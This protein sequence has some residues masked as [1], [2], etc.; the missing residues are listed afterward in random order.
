M[1]GA[2]HKVKNPL[3]SAA[4]EGFP[5]ENFTE[6]A[7]LMPVTSTTPAVLRDDTELNNFVG[8]EAINSQNSTG[9]GTVANVDSEFTPISLH[10]EEIKSPTNQPAKQGYLTSILSSLPNLSLSSIT[11]DTSGSQVNQGSEN[12]TGIQST[13][14]YVPSHDRH[15]SLRDISP[16][17]VS[18]FHD[19]RRTNFAGSGEINPG[20]TGGLSAPPQPPLPPAIPASTNGPI[21]Y[22]L[23]NQRRLKYA[24]PPDLISNTPK[25]YSAPVIQPL[26]PPQSTTS[27]IFTPNEPV[28]TTPNYQSFETSI[29]TNSPSI[30]HSTPE[31]LS[32]ANSLQE[33]FRSSPITAAVPY[34]SSTTSR[35]VT[36]PNQNLSYDSIPVVEK[37]NNSLSFP[38]SIPSQVLE[39]TTP[40]NTPAT[41]SFFAFDAYTG[42]RGFPPKP[43]NS[44]QEVTEAK[45]NLQQV[46]LPLP[47]STVCNLKPNS[48]T[49]PSVTFA[50]VSAVQVSEKL[51]HL[52]IEQ[53]EDLSGLSTETSPQAEE[54]KAESKSLATV[55]ASDNLKIDDVEGK[56]DSSNLDALNNAFVKQEASESTTPSTITSQTTSYTAH[57]NPDA[58]HSHGVSSN[59]QSTQQYY[60]PPSFASSTNL[61]TEKP[62]E[63]RSNLN[64]I[65]ATGTSV[66][67]TFS[68]P[69][70]NFTQSPSTF[71]N[72]LEGNNNNFPL[73][74]Y[75][76]NTNVSVPSRNDLQSVPLNSSINSHSVSPL[77]SA[78]QAQ[79]HNN[80]TS[81]ITSVTCA[82]SVQSPPPPLFYNANLLG[83]NELSKYHP[84]IGELYNPSALN[85]LASQAQ[86][87]FE[88][89]TETT[90]THDLT[91]GLGN[92]YFPPSPVMTTVP[93]PSGS[94]TLNPVQMS[95]N[96]LAGRTVTD[97]SLNTANVATGPLEKRMQYRGVYHHWF[98]RKEVENKVIWH[99][100]SMQDSLRLEEVHNSSEITPE[101]TVATDGGRYD[102]DILRR[103]R[104]PVYWTGPSTE[105]RRCSWFFKG[106][107]ESRYVPYDESTA[108]KLEEEYKQA[109]LMNIW[110]RRIDLNNG[111]YIIVHSATVQV[112]YLTATSPE[113]AASWGNSGGAGSRPRV[114]KRGLDEFHIEDGEPEKVDHLLFLVH[115]IGS[116]CDLK[117]RSVEEV[118][119]EFRSIALQLV[120]SHYRTASQQGIVN[121]IEVLPISWHTTL[122]SED[123]GIDKKLH[124]ITLESIPK[125]RHF[126][127]DTLLDILFY[128]SPVYCQTIMQTVGN[129]INRLHAL[130]KQRNPNFNGGIY[131]GGHSLGSLILFDLLCHQKPL[132][133][134]SSSEND[135]ENNEKRDE[136][137]NS[138]ESTTNRVLKRRLSKKISYV[139]GAAGTGQP[140]IHYPQLHFHPCA[141]F[142]LGSPVGMFVTVRGI[143][144]LG[145]DFVLPTC[146]AF[147]NIFHPF[148]PVAY[149]VEA[150]INPDAPKYQPMLIPHHKG[151]KRMHLELKETMARVGADLKQKVLDSVKNTWN[152]VYQLTPFHRPDNSAL[153][154]E[155]DKVVEEQLQQTPT[156]PV[157]QT[158]DDGGAELKIGK[159]NGG[160][161][162]D[163]VLQEAPFEYINEYIFALTSHVCYWESEDTMLMMLKEIYG[164]AGIQTDTQLPQQTLTIERTSP[165]PS[166][167]SSS[168]TKCDGSVPVV[169]V[170]GM[171]PTAPIS[172]KPIGPPPKSGF[173]RKS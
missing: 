23:G 56:I 25:Q 132:A 39:P 150:L 76:D 157:P 161:R 140:Y 95:I 52:L 89:F 17:I 101:T 167:S 164:S 43:F 171:N 12:V 60:Q 81:A 106:H 57:E 80:Q 94:A 163:Y 14:P 10:P 124:A 138:S 104:S 86:H 131:L 2:S 137:S 36:P 16:P 117:F 73:F 34:S 49:K 11:G 45:N 85:P 156:V 66:S 71:F 159:L 26:L 79:L 173:V 153:E 103:L 19:P 30:Q 22:R 61:F 118:V 154:R 15:N 6:N 50:P 102:V 111:E 58:L 74:Q 129:E 54:S 83:Q 122:H 121:R 133:D 144:M 146:P 8:Q 147:F 134:A 170:M 41:T 99:P 98:Y 149:R 130:F 169:P 148:D 64:Y 70:T 125:L 93:E 91:G 142:A 1:S 115:G 72:T 123:T 166:L 28:V 120:Q 62:A 88:N 151:R 35:S 105:V 141:F 82:A 51:E 136:D 68:D 145:E 75:K 116:V 59:V 78:T 3:L 40:Q 13:N 33:S 139:V 127:N 37:S 110:N 160:R 77:I 152:S 18:N 90:Q 31:C 108:A 109:C 5:F 65:P 9:S 143:D 162:I 119:D 27:T 38:R 7:L 46:D 113:L 20:S 168:S 4:G 114:I 63:Q 96:P 32:Q 128:T 165:S 100:F 107:T 29:S 53:K 155:I 126:T 172:E 24:P 135:T 92:I 97:A 44:D 48:E 87:F 112:H 55:E 158:N 84:S 42:Q 47:T 67:S 69:S 21:S